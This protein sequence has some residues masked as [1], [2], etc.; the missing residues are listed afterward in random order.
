MIKKTIYRII[1]Q[2]TYI[3]KLQLLIK[4]I[5]KCKELERISIAA[6]ADQTVHVL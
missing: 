4:I 3:Y 5:Q 1:Q 6:S 2:N